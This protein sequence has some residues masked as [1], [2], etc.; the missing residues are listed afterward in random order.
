MTNKAIAKTLAISVIG[1]AIASTAS[2]AI[3]QKMAVE[4]C[5]GIAKKGQNQC[6]N[7]K[8]ACAGQAKTNA[9]G[10]EWI[11]VLKG[12]CEKIVGGSLKPK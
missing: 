7:S 4:K 9:T 10:D 8:H 3:A 5:Y 6:G 1:A 12:N 11:M 2:S